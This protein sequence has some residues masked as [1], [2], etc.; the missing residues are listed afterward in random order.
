MYFYRLAVNKSCSNVA[1]STTDNEKH[2]RQGQDGVAERW[3]GVESKPLMRW[4]SFVLR[5]WT[6]QW[7]W[8]TNADIV[9]FSPAEAAVDGRVSG[10]KC[11]TTSNISNVARR[12][13]KMH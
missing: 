3:P 8:S 4:P 6:P 10:A 1:R 7:S 2:D 12:K 11:H 9:S 5:S 13:C